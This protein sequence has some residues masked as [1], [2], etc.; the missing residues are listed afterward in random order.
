MP[1]RS[2][3]LLASRWAGLEPSSEGVLCLAGRPADEKAS[4]TDVFVKIRPVNALSTAY[5]PPVG[6]FRGCPMCETGIPRQW[7]AHRSA[8]DEIDDQS[9]FRDLHALRECLA[10]ITR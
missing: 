1:A 9:V 4:D 6:A 2:S 7:H 8:V 3:G 5:Q 10:Q